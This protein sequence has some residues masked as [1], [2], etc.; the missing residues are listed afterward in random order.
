M[1]DSMDQCV[2][3]GFQRYLFVRISICD[4]LSIERWNI[5]YSLA[6]SVFLMFVDDQFY[7]WNKLCIYL[8]VAGFL[9][10]NH[11]AWGVGEGI[12]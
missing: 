11:F 6:V 4:Y 3:K 9:L 1:F 12:H 2:C 8:F 10:L 5:L 7:C